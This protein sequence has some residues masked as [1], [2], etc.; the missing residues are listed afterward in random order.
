[1]ELSIEMLH[2]LGM[3]WLDSFLFQPIFQLN[4]DGLSETVQ[5]TN[6]LPLIQ[7]FEN[8]SVE[9]LKMQDTNECEVTESSSINNNSNVLSDKEQS[10]IDNHAKNE[11]TP[12][13]MI[14]NVSKRSP[15]RPKKTGVTSQVC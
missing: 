9:Q 2:L 5:Q 12:V 1:M 4:M 3:T 10:T 8:G 14:Q 7:H 13:S 6:L 11:S 15:G